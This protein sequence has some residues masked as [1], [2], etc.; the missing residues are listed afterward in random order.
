MNI[1]LDELKIELDCLKNDLNFLVGKRIDKKSE[2]DS[3]ELDSDDYIDSYEYM[4]DECYGEFMGMYASHILKNCDPIAYR[5]GLNDYVYGIDKSESP[6]YK[7]IE[8]DMEEIEGAIQDIEDRIEEIEEEIEEIEGQIADID[9][10][11]S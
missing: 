10:T 2:L 6:D 9:T 1:E 4:L 8:T 11:N 5:C 3:F 7:E